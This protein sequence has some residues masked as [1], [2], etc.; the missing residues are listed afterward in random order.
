MAI[1][2]LPKFGPAPAND[3]YL[4]FVLEKLTH[5]VYWQEYFRFISN[6]STQAA[7]TQEHHFFT[8]FWKGAGFYVQL[9][10]IFP[11]SDWL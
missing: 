7:G 1:I 6:R 4:D 2:E 5:N 8:D 11:C 3:P 10:L 9:P